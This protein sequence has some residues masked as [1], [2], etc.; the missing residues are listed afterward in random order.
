MK[1]EGPPSII[2][3][4][5]HGMLNTQL[6][7]WPLLKNNYEKLKNTQQ[8]VL[9]ID[10]SKVEVMFNPERI[11]SSAAKTDNKSIHERPCFLCRKN[12]PAEQEQMDCCQGSY[13]ILF[14]PYPIFPNHLTIASTSHI[15]QTIKGKIADMMM[16]SELL[17]DNV[18]FYN[19]PFSGA[20][21]PDHFHFQ[22]LQKKHL[23]FLQQCK[24]SSGQNIRKRIQSV[25]VLTNDRS[26]WPVNY[27]LFTSETKT[28]ITVVVENFFSQWKALNCLQTEPMM[29]IIS[30][31]EKKLY[32][33]VIFPREKQRPEQYYRTGKDKFLL[34]PAS[35]EMAGTM[36]LPRQEDFDKITPEILKDILNQVTLDTSD[37]ERLFEIIEV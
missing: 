9:D 27:L 25:N 4:G 7:S 30:W 2:N 26:Q 14:N 8:K 36:I 23:P 13:D 17:S 19:G 21:A 11:K 5:L 31:F 33:C 22:S 34:S 37:M 16:I 15:Q 12:R 18:V 20:S 10:G 1:A 29:N 28:E 24:A 3:K 32:S 6:K 35:V